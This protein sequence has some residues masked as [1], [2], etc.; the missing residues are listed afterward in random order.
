MSFRDLFVVPEGGANSGVK[1]VQSNTPEKK[2][3]ETSFPKTTFPSSSETKFPSTS[4]TKFPSTSTDKFPPI[5][6]N[7][8][9]SDPNNPF[10]EQILDVYDKGFTKLNQPGYDFFEF[11]KSVSK[12]GINNSQAYEMAFEMGQAM[13]AN[14]SKQSLISQADYYISELIKV[15]TGFNADG[16]A[17]INDLSNKKSSESQTLSSDISSLKLQL[18]AIQNQIHSKENALAE[19][20]GKYQPNINEISYKLAANDMAKERFVSNITQ[21]KNNITNNLK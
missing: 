19:I 20:D 7:D 3:Q 6:F 5:K 16:Q 21:V 14:V 10:L 15:Y 12:A 2:T 17:K 8:P 13:D 9:K 1:P 18:E 4:E 11:Y